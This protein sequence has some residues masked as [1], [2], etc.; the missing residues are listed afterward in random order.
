LQASSRNQLAGFGYQRS[1]TSRDD[2]FMDAA[3]RYRVDTEKLQRVVA[4]EFAAK[5]DKKTNQ[6]EG[7]LGSSLSRSIL[8]SWRS[9]NLALRLFY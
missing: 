1:T 8:D 4:K 7:S 2:V 6:G 9:T 3:K 5:R